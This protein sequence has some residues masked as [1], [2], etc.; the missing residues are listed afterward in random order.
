MDA[1]SPTDL[2]STPKPM[3][4]ADTTKMP[5]SEEG[6]T[7]VSFGRKWIMAIVKATKPIMIQRGVPE[8]QV[9]VPPTSVVLNCANCA[10][11]ITIASPFTN[12]K[13][14]GCGT[15]LMNFPSLRSPI[16]TFTLFAHRIN[17]PKT[18]E[19]TRMTGAS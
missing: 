19:R 16:L 12:P 6:K 17:Q 5:A 9:V 2:V 18:A 8:S 3:M 14:T 15:S 1:I 4:I 13:I 11:A 10:M 7:L